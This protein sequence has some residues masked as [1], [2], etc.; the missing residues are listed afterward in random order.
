MEQ[1]TDVVTEAD[2]K[3]KGGERGVVGKA[4]TEL[5]IKQRW[6]AF[7]DENSLTPDKRD[8][9]SLKQFA[10]LQ[11]KTGDDGTANAWLAHKH[12]VGAT[13]RSDSNIKA[14]REARVATRTA[15]RKKK[16]EGGAK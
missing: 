6:H 1:N 3:R 16:G 9:V 15:H 14:A 4:T 8:Y 11:V 2:V 13:K 7:L 5:T 12:G 10:R